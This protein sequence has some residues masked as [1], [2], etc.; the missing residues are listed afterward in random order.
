MPSEVYLLVE[1]ATMSVKGRGMM[2][3]M[4][5]EPVTTASLM[6]YLAHLLVLNH[7]C[8]RRPH[9]TSLNTHARYCIIL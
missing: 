2:T 6:A 7:S 8:G 4:T 1:Y 9:L 3:R 5:E